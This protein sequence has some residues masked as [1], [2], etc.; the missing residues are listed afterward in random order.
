MP[1]ESTLGAYQQYIHAKHVFVHP[2]MTPLEH[3]L[4]AAL[5]IQG[6]LGEAFEAEESEAFA[7]EVGD[8]LSYVMLAAGLLGFDVDDW[9]AEPAVHERSLVLA[10]YN[11]PGFA[12]QRLLLDGAR[13]AEYVKKRLYQGQPVPREP[14]RALL[15]R[16]TVR[17]VLWSALHGHTLVQVLLHN[18]QK[19]DSRFPGPPSVPPDSAMPYKR[20]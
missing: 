7:L 9:I 20:A 15:R 18:Q 4:G 6:E 19:V 8:A 17:L 5:G 12:A 14:A 13:F 3:L 16:M 1:S 2:D 10:R 11:E